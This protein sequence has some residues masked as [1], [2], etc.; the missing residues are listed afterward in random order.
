V[1]FVHEEF[2]VRSWSVIRFAVGKGMDAYREIIDVE[3]YHSFI[4]FEF[5]VFCMVEETVGVCD[6]MR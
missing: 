5:D 1:L 3:G 4:G 2:V 6:G